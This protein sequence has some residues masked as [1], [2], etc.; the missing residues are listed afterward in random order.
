V[1]SARRW[2]EPRSWPGRSH[3]APRRSRRPRSWPR[4][5]HLGGGA[6]AESSPGLVCRGDGDAKTR[7]RQHPVWVNGG[8]C[9][10]WSTP[11]SMATSTPAGPLAPRIPRR[12]CLGAGSAGWR[13][14]PSARYPGSRPAGG[15]R[16]PQVPAGRP[17]PPRR[18]RPGGRQRAAEGQQPSRMSPH[19]PPRSQ[20][21]CAAVMACDT[22]SCGGCC[23]TG[24]WM[25]CKRSGV[26]IPSAPP[27][28]THRQGS[29]SGRDSRS[30]WPVPW[31]PGF[32]LATA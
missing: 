31:P 30:S 12:A 15:Q 28:T 27:H 3:P 26:Q 32:A 14:R 1:S 13:W 7:K 9:C 4:P 6:D 20:R 16:R 5:L 2:R 25:A 10:R 17:R 11:T 29:R 21:H 19:E 8:C 18:P 22:G 24:S 23:A